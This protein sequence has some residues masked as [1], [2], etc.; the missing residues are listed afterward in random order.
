[1]IEF[2]LDHISTVDF[3]LGGIIFINAHLIFCPWLSGHVI[4]RLQG[5]CGIF[6]TFRTR[7]Y[8][9]FLVFFSPSDI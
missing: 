4:I 5:I 6:V 8:F 1:M 2:L 3:I 7:F 9:D